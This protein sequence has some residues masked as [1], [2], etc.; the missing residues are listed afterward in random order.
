MEGVDLPLH[1]GLSWVNCWFMVEGSFVEVDKVCGGSSSSG[2]AIPGVMPILPAFE[3]GVV[4]S[5]RYGLGNT[6]LHRSP[7]SSPLVRGSGSAEVHG[8]G[9]VVKCRRGSGRV[10]RGCPVSDR[11]SIRGGVWRGPTPHV[12]LGALEEWLGRL[13]YLLGGISPISR[14]RSPGVAL[15]AEHTLDDLAGS[16]GVDCFLFHLF[17]S[18]WERG[19][20]YFGGD[21][22]GESSEE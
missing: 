20:H 21:G 19:L 13:S 2:G 18:S 3:A 14:V 11:I 17:V 5:V 7:P 15:V 12:L 1:R 9:S 6:V 16:G 8:D 22:S 10:Y 4:V